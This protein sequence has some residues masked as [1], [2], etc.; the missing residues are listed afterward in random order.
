MEA[1]NITGSGVNVGQ[2]W[3]TAVLPTE[4]D[5]P[6]DVGQ[7]TKLLTMAQECTK[8]DELYKHVQA[9]GIGAETPIAYGSFGPSGR[10]D[11][12]QAPL[13]A[14]LVN[15]MLRAGCHVKIPT[16]DRYAFMNRNLM[17][18]WTEFVG[19]GGIS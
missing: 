7:R 11:T 5:A 15:K 4:L 9:A 6:L 10:V 19:V 12:A 2:P 13:K 17:A 14:I 3:E 8:E 1:T 16:A 18:G